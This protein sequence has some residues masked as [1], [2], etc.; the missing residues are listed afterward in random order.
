MTSDRQNIIDFFYVVTSDCNKGQKR[1]KNLRKLNKPCL[2][3]CMGIFIKILHVK[4]LVSK[5]EGLRMIQVVLSH[6]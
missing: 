1:F 2:N 4:S 3:H 5:H 6:F